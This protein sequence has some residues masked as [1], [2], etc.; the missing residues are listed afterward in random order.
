LQ[1]KIIPVKC[2]CCH[3]LDVIVADY[4]G[5]NCPRQELTSY[6]LLVLR[7]TKAGMVTIWMKYVGHLND[8]HCEKR[9]WMSLNIDRSGT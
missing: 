1:S 6:H 4:S 9:S 2:L 3:K 8:V 5:N 7:D